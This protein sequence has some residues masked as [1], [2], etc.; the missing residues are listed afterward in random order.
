MN[1]RQWLIKEEKNGRAVIF[2]D[3]DETLVRTQYLVNSRN[4]LAPRE[5][6]QGLADRMAIVNQLPLG[7]EELTQAWEEKGAKII[8]IDE[9]PEDWMNKW[10]ITRSRPHAQETLKTL[11][12]M[13]EV[14]ILT[15]GGTAF[16]RMV[17]EANEF[18]IPPDR[19]LGKDRYNE[20]NLIAQ[21]A[22]TVLIDDL[23][24][25]GNKP[26]EIDIDEI[27]E[28]KPWLGNDPH[29]T[30]LT[31]IPSRV[32]EALGGFNEA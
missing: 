26:H 12:Q 20:A 25:G 30:A 15:S 17:I 4:D 16:Q 5:P 19:V 29:D 1:F 8:K 3:L 14:Y 28:I 31:L 9:S 7:P 6:E 23:P 2:C 18:P 13:G 11:Q 27:I 10:F 21:N 32:K 24:G 22:N